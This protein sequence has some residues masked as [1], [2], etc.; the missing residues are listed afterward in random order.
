MDKLLIIC[1]PTATGKTGLAL[2]LA[3]KFDGELVSADSRQVYKM[4]NI[5]TGKDLPKDV[6]SPK[7]HFRLG[8]SYEIEDVKVWGYDLVSPGKDY[9]VAQYVKF[10]RKVIKNILSRKKLPILVGGT[11]LYI[12][13]V[14]DGIETM[15]VPKNKKL[16]ERLEDRSAGELFEQLA[17]IDPIKAASMNSSDKKNPRRLVRAIE[18]AQW[19]IKGKKMRKIEPFKIDT[20]FIGVKVDRKI[21]E[22]DVDKRIENRVKEGIEDEIKKLLKKG[23]SWGDQ[24]MNTLG[25]KEWRGYFKGK[26]KKEKVIRDWEL[27][28]KRYAKRQM[29]WFKKDKRIKWF[30]RESKSYFENIEKEVAKWYKN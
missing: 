6:A 11:G 7:R 21:L 10:A 25:Y 14:V 5:G 4:M 16:R 17:Q 30:N 19:G 3:N 15:S 20:L 22:K 12:D 1:G 27:D 13:G 9:S 8:P 23:I 2:H 18:V 26:K 29:T 24:S 28:E